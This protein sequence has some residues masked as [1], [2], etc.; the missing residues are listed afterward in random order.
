MHISSVETRKTNVSTPDSPGANTYAAGAPTRGPRAWYN[1]NPFTIT[2]RMPIIQ[3]VHATPL[4][5]EKPSTQGEMNNQ[6]PRMTEITSTVVAAASTPSATS[7]RITPITP[8]IHAS[9]ALDPCAKAK[10]QGEMNRRTPN[11][12]ETQSCQRVHAF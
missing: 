8:T 10:T 7:A 1:V 4:S 9:R 11:T 3:A 2:N 6:T 5:V 12:R